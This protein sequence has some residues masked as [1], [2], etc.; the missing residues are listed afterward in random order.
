MKKKK[1][2][3]GLLILCFILAALFM[4]YTV[5]QKIFSVAIQKEA[6]EYLYVPTGMSYV[7]LLEVI[8]KENVIKDIQTFKQLAKYKK[9]SQ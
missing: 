9:L 8:E 1:L 5:Y 3:I 6:P 4:F 2:V 7:E